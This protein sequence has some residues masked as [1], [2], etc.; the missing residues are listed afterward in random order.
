MDELKDRPILRNS[1]GI[2]PNRFYPPDPC[3]EQCRFY[4]FIDSG[5]GYCIG[6]PPTV[7]PKRRTIW[8]WV[9]GIYPEYGLYDFY[10]VVAWC[11][12]ACGLLGPQKRGSDG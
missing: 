12:P 9:R 6:V 3:C 4:K 5:Y 2:E 10:Q 8:Q 7:Q 1:D 11:T